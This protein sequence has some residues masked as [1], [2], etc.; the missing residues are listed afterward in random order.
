M[1]VTVRD[2]LSLDRGVSARALV[3]GVDARVSL[4]RTR[5]DGGDGD[6]GFWLGR[7][8]SLAL[9]EERADD[10]EGGGVIGI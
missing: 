4:S 10:L 6:A 7:G 2:D 3:C 5:G 8:D 1:G 9:E